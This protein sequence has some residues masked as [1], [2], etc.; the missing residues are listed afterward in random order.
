MAELT[1]ADGLCVLDAAV[2]YLHMEGRWDA[3]TREVFEQAWSDLTAAMDA[4]DARCS[5]EHVRRDNVPVRER[6]L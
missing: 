6:D 4:E 3:A 2:C 1:Y 5:E